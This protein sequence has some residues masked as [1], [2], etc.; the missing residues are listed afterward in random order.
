MTKYILHFTY[1]SEPFWWVRF[2]RKGFSHCY[3]I[4]FLPKGCIVIN[5][6]LT[7]LEVNYYKQGEN[8]PDNLQQPAIAIDITDTL[9]TDKTQPVFFRAFT[10][11]EVIKSVLGIQNRRIITPYQ[12]YKYALAQKHKAI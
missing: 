1:A 10:C 11:V 2:L 6:N 5:P 8:L 9:N 4:E 12:L 3:L 7:S